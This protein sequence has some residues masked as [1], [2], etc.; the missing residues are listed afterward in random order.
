MSQ[1]SINQGFS[2]YFCLMIEGSGSR[3]PKNTWI[4]WIRIRIRIR[5]TGLCFFLRKYSKIGRSRYPMILNNG[6]SGTGLPVIIAFQ[7]KYGT[8]EKPESRGLVLIGMSNVQTVNE[9]TF[10][11][12]STNVPTSNRNETK[13]SE[14]VP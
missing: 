2:Y 13:T 14:F 12:R 1:N 4:R 11:K 5:N 8:R 9:Q 7:L 6:L 3:R 10:H